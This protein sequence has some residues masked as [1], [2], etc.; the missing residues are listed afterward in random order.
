MESKDLRLGNWVKHEDNLL[1]VISI[2][3]HMVCCKPNWRFDNFE[4]INGI[5]LSPDILLKARFERR[6]DSKFGFTVN[7]FNVGLFILRQSWVDYD[8]TW[9]AFTHLT[10]VRLLYLH[11][12]QNLYFALTGTELTIQL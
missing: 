12:L 4:Y 8:P 11:Q 5:P 1:K 9:F 7:V 6:K 3:Y 10:D 2:D